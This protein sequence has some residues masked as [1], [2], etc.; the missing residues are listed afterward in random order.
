MDKIVRIL[1]KNSGRGLTITEL[2]KASELSRS[3]IRTILARMEGA[4]KVSYRKVGMAKLY[5]L[6]GGKDKD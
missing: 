5:F 4:G 1:R 6:K 2:V 3:A